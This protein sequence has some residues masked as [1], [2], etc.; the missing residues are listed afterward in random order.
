MKSGIREKFCVAVLLCSML[1][2]MSCDKHVP[3]S[4][5]QRYTQADVEFDSALK[6]YLDK[7]YDSEI[8]E[9]AVTGDKVRVSG[10]YRGTGEFWVVEVPPFMDVVRLS[11]PLTEVKPESSSFSF[12]VDRH[13]RLSG[14]LGYD[15]L[16]SKWAI[17][18]KT[19]KGGYDLVSAAHYADSAPIKSHPAPVPLRNKKGLGGIFN[20]AYLTDFD[21]LDLGSATLNMYVT[22]FAYLSE[23]P[24]RIAHEYE[25]KTYWFDESHM[26]NFDYLLGEA[27]KR[28]MAVA[29]ILLVQRAGDAADRELGELLMDDNCNG[30]TLTLPD[31]TKAES[32]HCFAAITDF[33]AQRYSRDDA[34]YGRI[35]K[36]IVMNEIDIASSWANIGDRPENVHADYYI[37]ILRLVNNIVRQYDENT[38]VL[39]SFCHSW[40]D[41]AGGFPAKSMIETVNKMGKKEGD[42]RWG[43][44]YHSY[45]WNLLDPKCWAC[46]SSTFS[47]NTGCIS[48]K[49]LEVMNKWIY[50]PENMYKGTQKRSVWL[51]EAGLNAPSYSEEDLVLQAAGTAYA[52]KKVAALDGI[53]AWQWHNWFDNVGDGSGALL[54]LRKFLDE[55]NDGEPKE[56]WHVFKAAGT[57]SEDEVFEKYLDVIGID[58]WDGIIVPADEIK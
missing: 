41:P 49:N 45:P 53:D 58:S 22:M 19:E 36:W 27:G 48:F 6:Y 21:E 51:S 25:G 37:K 29:A 13:T 16:L 9:V 47:M 38:E 2:F 8:T 5:E 17:V 57:D 28:G 33:L 7:S 26:A 50:M 23:G 30:G 54:G 46:E 56:A 11:E 15:R 35:S 4:E 52:W 18:R 12:E 44:A 14:G 40:T 55:D 43:L 31:M 10:T 1:G 42:Y 20:N 34:A 3:V 39:A 24:G 32:V